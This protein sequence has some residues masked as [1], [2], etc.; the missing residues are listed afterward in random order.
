MTAAIYFE[1]YTF[2]QNKIR[3]LQNLWAEPPNRVEMW[4]RGDNFYWK[5]NTLLFLPESIDTHLTSWVKE[6][7]K[8]NLKDILSKLQ[9]CML[10]RRDNSNGV[11]L[12]SRFLL[13]FTGFSL[14]IIFFITTDTC[15]CNEAWNLIKKWLA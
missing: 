8:E 10:Y 7:S 11:M 13:R 4:T 2:K 6:D 1:M 15:Y 5:L 9:A 12:L 3:K 14:L